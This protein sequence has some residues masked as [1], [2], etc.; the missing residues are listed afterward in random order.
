MFGLTPLTRAATGIN[1]LRH[2]VCLSIKYSVRASHSG[3]FPL[4]F[5]P[6]FWHGS[7]RQFTAGDTRKKAITTEEKK[8]SLADWQAS[9]KAELRR[10]WTD[11]RNGE[12]GYYM[13]KLLSS[14]VYCPTAQ[15]SP[16]LQSIP[17]LPMTGG[18]MVLT[19]AWDLR[20]SPYSRV[21]NMLRGGGNMELGT[22]FHQGCS[23]GEDIWS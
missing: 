16:T 17:H 14:Y 1:S 10:R 9:W 13:T 4:E 18:S 20:I 5:L 21:K 23:K 11:W 6:T 7:G 3:Y 12:V 15:G 8:Q 22:I 2:K 19:S